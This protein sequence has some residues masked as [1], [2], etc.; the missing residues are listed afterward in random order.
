M[1]VS[2]KHPNGLCNDVLPYPVWKFECFWVLVYQSDSSELVD[3]LLFVRIRL[4]LGTAGVIDIL[5]GVCLVDARTGAE[6]FG[7]RISDTNLYSSGIW[8]IL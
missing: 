8:F 2:R 7:S 5:A 3:V 6:R 1:L 4:L